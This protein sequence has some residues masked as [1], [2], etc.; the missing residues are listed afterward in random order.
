MK[1]KLIGEVS[2]SVEDESLFEGHKLPVSFVCDLDDETLSF[3]NERVK[4][5]F[6]VPVELA[7][8]DAEWSRAVGE[9]LARAFQEAA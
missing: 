6:Q 4:M 8:A 9:I 1:V 2:V 7:L 5:S 3:E